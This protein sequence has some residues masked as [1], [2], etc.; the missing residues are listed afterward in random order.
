MKFILPLLIIFSMLSGYS[1]EIP[2]YNLP[3]IKV[4]N[5]LVKSLKNT[6]SIL[7]N[8][9]EKKV[10]KIQFYGQS[11]VSGIDMRRITNLLEDTYP[12]VK[13]VILNN[14][15]GGYQAPKLVRT[16]EHDLYPQYPDLIIFHVYGG[17]ENGELEEIFYNI[18]NRLTSDVI[19]FDHHISYVDNDLGQ[20]KLNKKQDENSKIIKNLAIKYNFGFIGV[21]DVWK[22]Y[23]ELN[24]SL[25]IK[26]LLRDIVHPN[27]EGKIL[28]EWILME[29]FIKAVQKTNEKSNM[30]SEQVI[31][32]QGAVV[33]FTFNGNRFDVLPTKRN[34]GANFSIKLDGI[35]I[36]KHNDLY[37]VSRTSSFPKQW[38]PT[39]NRIT[40]NKSV[41]QIEEKWII[42]I[43]N[44]NLENQSFEFELIGDVSGYQGKGKSGEDFVSLNRAIEILASDMS[45]FPYENTIKEDVIQIS[46]KVYPLFINPVSIEKVEEI[47]LARLLDNKMHTVELRVEQGTLLN[48]KLIFYQPESLKLEN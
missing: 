20:E 26:D 21:R 13:F 34:I 30:I 39:F 27:D 3:T 43:K 36:D 47:N 46:F 19:I 25:T 45:A 14:A 5:Q 4:S 28:L 7:T 17:I 31:K 42:H 9:S 48:S 6:S 8:T 1:Q 41:R 2:K 12:N 18:K 16:A 40:L 11:I 38:W 15:I 44:L 32:D 10:F 33:K 24:T 22:N 35:P 37:A 29:H 23:L